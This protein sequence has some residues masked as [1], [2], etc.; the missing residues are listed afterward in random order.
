[1]QGADTRRSDEHHHLPCQTKED[2]MDG[3]ELKKVLA[4][5]GIATLVTAVGAAVPDQLQAASG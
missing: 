5:L 4:S 3:K 2:A 1:M